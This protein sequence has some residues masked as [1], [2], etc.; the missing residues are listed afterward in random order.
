MS[1]S[2]V[3][4][5]FYEA[6]SAAK[7]DGAFFSMV[8]DAPADGYVFEDPKNKNLRTF[9]PKAEFEAQYQLAPPLKPPRQPTP[10]EDGVKSVVQ[11]KFYKEGSAAKV[12][13][14]FTSMVIDAPADGY[15]FEDPKNKNLRTFLPKAEFEAKFQCAPAKAATASPRPKSPSCG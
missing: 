13:G 6:G 14:A 11:A 1:K 12:D 5:R 9:M 3:Q 10:A 7:I 8:I 15:V 4:G 2:I